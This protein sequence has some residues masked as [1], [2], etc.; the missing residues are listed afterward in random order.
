MNENVT[1]PKLALPDGG[2]RLA[3]SGTAE[4][5]HVVTP[6]AI[7]TSHGAI[8]YLEDI[9]VSFDGFRALRKLSLAID[10]G[11]LRCVI[12]PNGAGKTTMMDVITGKTRPDS[13]KAFL[14]QTLDLARMTEPQIA[15]AGIGR[16]FQKPTVFERHPVWENLELAMAADKRWFASLR[17]RLD[18]AA[19]ARIEETL[20][21][22]GLEDSAYRLA[23][24]LSHGQKQRLEIGMLLMQRPALLLLDEPAAGM[25]DHETMELAKLLNT[26]RGTCSMMV[27][28][29]DMEFVAALAGDT[30]RVTVM[31]EGAVLAH[32]TLDQVKR[33][34]AVIESYLGR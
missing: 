34:E 7:D 8:L 21:L 13:G 10:V 29:H 17:A 31:A 30:G 18:R 5:S 22:I 4:M 23:G 3:V 11:E 27:V 9:E 19:Q 20:A 14:G 12:G 6:G 32:G 15:R 33:D 25:T 28:E 1:I 24:E 2:D 16:K 26:L